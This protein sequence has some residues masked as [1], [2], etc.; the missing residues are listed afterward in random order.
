[1]KIAFDVDGTLHDG[2]WDRIGNPREEIVAKFKKYQD[3]GHEMFIWSGA[4]TT[5]ARAVAK[6]LGLRAKIMKKGSFTPDIAVD[7]NKK[8]HFGKRNIYV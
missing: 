7:N 3:A 1:M 6:K 2:T 8:T 5:H 4:G